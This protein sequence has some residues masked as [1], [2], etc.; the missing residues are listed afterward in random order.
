MLQ[1]CWSNVSLLLNLRYQEVVEDST[2]LARLR[3]ATRPYL[4]DHLTLQAL[5]PPKSRALL[6]ALLR[7]GWLPQPPGASDFC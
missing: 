6:A 1:V 7:S 3:P 5:S 4:L 2:L